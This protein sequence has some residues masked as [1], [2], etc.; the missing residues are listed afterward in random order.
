MMTEYGISGIVGET[1]FAILR[2]REQPLA[3]CRDLFC[4]KPLKMELGQIGICF[5]QFPPRYSY[6]QAS[7]QHCP[8]ADCAIVDSA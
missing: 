2:L 3:T 4:A 6:P 7:Y 5:E 1:S 8:S